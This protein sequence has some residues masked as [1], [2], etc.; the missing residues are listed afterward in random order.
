MSKF[1]VDAIFEA[2]NAVAATIEKAIP[3]DELREKMF[4][5]NTPKRKAAKLRKLLNE[6]ARYFKKHKLT[7]NEVDE[8]AKLINMDNTQFITLLKKR[9]L[10]IK[11]NK[12]GRKQQRSRNPTR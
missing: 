8:Y 1:P 10:T 9:L 7:S 4:D 3:S 6:S 11:T 5:E 2:V 12:H